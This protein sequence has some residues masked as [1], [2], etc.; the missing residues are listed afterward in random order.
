MFL[1]FYNYRNMKRFDETHLSLEQAASAFAALGSEQR[2]SVL[3][4]LVRAGPDGL[5]M[6]DLGEKTGV[7]GS[8]L[9]HHLKFLT[10]ADLVVQ[11]K[12]GRTIICTSV[13]YDVIEALSEFLLQNCCADSDTSHEGHDHG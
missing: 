7:T 13:A 10:A 8:T 12:Q 11:A 3:R 1:Y 2:L 6:G 4:T 9:T 5:S